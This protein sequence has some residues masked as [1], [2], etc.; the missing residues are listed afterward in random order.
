MYPLLFLFFSLW[1]VDSQFDFP[2]TTDANAYALGIAN[3]TT[4]ET[5]AAF[6][7]D[8]SSIPTIVLSKIFP[9]NAN[10]SN[11]TYDSTTSTVV[12]S[13]YV[14]GLPKGRFVVYWECFNT[15][16]DL[17]YQVFNNDFTPYGSRVTIENDVAIYPK[18]I[19]YQGN[20]GCVWLSGA[21]VLKFQVLQDNGTQYVSL[22]NSP[23]SLMTAKATINKIFD[24]FSDST[25]KLFLT[26]SED[27]GRAIMVHPFSLSSNSVTPGSPFN[28]TGESPTDTKDFNSIYSRSTMANG[29]LYYGYNVVSDSTGKN[30][31]FF[32]IISPSGVFVIAET[33]ISSNTNVYCYNVICLSNGNCVDIISVI[34]FSNFQLS[35]YITIISESGMKV[36][37]PINLWM[38]MYFWESQMEMVFC[39][40]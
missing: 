34:D 6:V 30:P 11:A 31:R 33:N 15:T 39:F 24:V 12:S 9:T 25:G 20:I 3:L 10:I 1:V 37:K 18:M 26:L 7:R 29:N 36:V 40:F 28:V 21:L 35:F 8:I 27:S 14:L 4:G 13:L 2:L 22:Y 38:P 16:L 17:Y 32:R 5:I 19:N 23:L